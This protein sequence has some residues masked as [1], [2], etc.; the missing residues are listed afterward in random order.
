MSKKYHIQRREFLN[1]LVDM[2]AY[3]I[4]IV[5]DTRE[6]AIDDVDSWKWG[7][8]KLMFSDCYRNISFEFDLSSIADREN[9]LHKIRIISEVVNSFSKRRSKS[10]RPRSN[11]GIRSAARTCV[12]PRSL[13]FHGRR[14]LCREDGRQGQ[15]FFHDLTN[16]NAASRA[17]E[18]GERV[19]NFCLFVLTNLLVSP[20]VDAS[21]QPRLPHRSVARLAK[22]LA[23]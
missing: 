16:T 18:D 15:V 12:E 23:F 17:C 19:D 11:N 2:P 8:I 13:I 1:R 6:I 20:S 4:A 3:A 7:E 14:P 5:E 21:W 22:A 9:S 10:R